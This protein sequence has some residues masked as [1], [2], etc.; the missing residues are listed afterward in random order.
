MKPSCCLQAT[1]GRVASR[2]SGISTRCTDGD[3]TIKPGCCLLKD[4][5]SHTLFRV[6]VLM[7]DL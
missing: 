2:W 4:P 3:I 1:A 5:K 6:S 7:V